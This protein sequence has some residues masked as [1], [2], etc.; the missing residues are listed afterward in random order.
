MHLC[1]KITLFYVAYAYVDSEG[2]TLTGKCCILFKQ[3]NALG[4]L[5]MKLKNKGASIVLG[6]RSGEGLKV[7]YLGGWK[8]ARRNKKRRETDKT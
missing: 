2:Q 4:T 5:F 1:R 8:P 6:Q 3:R 7:F